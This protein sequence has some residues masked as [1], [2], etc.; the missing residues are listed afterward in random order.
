MTKND[1]DKSLH[2]ESQGR[3]GRRIDELHCSILNRFVE[4]C[5]PLYDGLP[6]W[7]LGWLPSTALV[8]PDGPHLQMILD[9]ACSGEQLAIDGKPLEMGCIYGLE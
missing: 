2:V 9:N 6:K 4:I 5:F 3:I 7:L 1:V 8:V